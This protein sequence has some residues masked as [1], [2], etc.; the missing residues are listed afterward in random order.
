MILSPTV[1]VDD[2]S[3]Y[4]M[5]YTYGHSFHPNGTMTAPYGTRVANGWFWDKRDYHDAYPP[6][7]F[8][9]RM[10]PQTVTHQVCYQLDHLTRNNVD[11]SCW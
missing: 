6:N 1:Q 8:P 2:K 7:P 11:M 4:I 5:H 10:P 3:P 9:H